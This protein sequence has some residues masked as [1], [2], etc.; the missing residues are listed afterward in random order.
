MRKIN[1]KS[2]FELTAAWVGDEGITP[3]ILEYSVGTRKVIASFDGQTWKNC[4][5]LDDKH[6]LVFFDQ[7]H[8][9]LGSLKC[10]LTYYIDN[11]RY[12][13]GNKKVSIPLETNIVLVDGPSDEVITDLVM[14]VSPNY[15]RGLSAFEIAQKYGFEGTEEEWLLSLRANIVL[16]GDS[17][18]V[19]DGKKFTLTPLVEE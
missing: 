18:L 7:H 5:K 8:F 14:Q 12:A 9:G 1:Y 6:I 3:F 15:Q 2:D 16:E 4:E 10:E 13:D 11:E 17:T 19:I